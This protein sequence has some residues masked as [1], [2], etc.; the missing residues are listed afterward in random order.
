M[1]SSTEDNSNF[2]WEK[3][4]VKL[5]TKV[6][7]KNL[8]NN[9]MC[10]SASIIYRNMTE[11][12]VYSGHTMAVFSDIGFKFLFQ[13]LDKYI[14]NRK[15]CENMLKLFEKGTD[16]DLFKKAFEI[17]KTDMLLKG[18][19]VLS[20][21]MK[22]HMSSRKVARGYVSFLVMTILSFTSGGIEVSSNK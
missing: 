16:P 17:K 10:L 4:T 22:R 7:K 3:G 20:A 2:F 5:V 11:Y 9:E 14:E 21:V 6:L 12:T 8:S 19:T 18:F 13:V 15:I 1:L